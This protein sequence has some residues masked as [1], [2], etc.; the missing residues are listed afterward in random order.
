MA[1]KVGAGLAFASSRVV[2]VLASCIA[3]AGDRTA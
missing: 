1:L 2:E 3:A